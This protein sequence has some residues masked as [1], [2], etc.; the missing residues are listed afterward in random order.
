MQNKKQYE[1]IV[2]KNNVK[3]KHDKR[4]FKKNERLTFITHPKDAKGQ[5][6]SRKEHVFSWWSSI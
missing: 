5:Q 4:F 2:N 6:T 1:T 3:K